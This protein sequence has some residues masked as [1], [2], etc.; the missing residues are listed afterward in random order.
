[1]AVKNGVSSAVV[2]HG[3]QEDLQDWYHAAD[4][5]VLPTAYDPC[6]NATLEAPYELPTKPGPISSP[7]SVTVTGM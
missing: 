7:Q 6:S 4:V 5:L 2:F 1:M 3:P